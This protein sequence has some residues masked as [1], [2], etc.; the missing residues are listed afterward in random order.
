MVIGEGT[1]IG[2]Q[3]FLHSAG[4]LVIGRHVGIA[5]AVKIVTSS[6]SLAELDRPIL[7]G[8]LEFASVEVGDG[9]D[10]GTG[11]VILPG[12]RIGRFAQVGAGAVVA[13]DVDDYAVV[14]GVPARLIR[15]RR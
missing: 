2:Q 10:I 9:S 14:A 8:A 4:G 7:H 11:T 1:W 12:V 13:A 15:M 6:H 3:A 5:P